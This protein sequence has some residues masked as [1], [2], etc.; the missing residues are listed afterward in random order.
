[1]SEN[2]Q[3]HGPINPY[4][5]ITELIEQDVRNISEKLMRDFHIIRAYNS[6]LSM[7]A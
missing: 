7:I 1:M 4:P 3:L 2:I 5:N 6:I